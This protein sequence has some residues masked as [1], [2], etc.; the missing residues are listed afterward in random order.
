MECMRCK[1]EMF[2]AKFKADTFGTGAY[3]TN[4]KKGLLE[5]EKQCTVSCYVCPKC[6]YVELH[7]DEPEKLKLD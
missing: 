3:L 4:K 5:S 7:A 2:D 1:V 6:G